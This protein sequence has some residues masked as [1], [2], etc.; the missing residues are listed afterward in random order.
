M[1]QYLISVLDDDTTDT[2][3]AEEMAADRCLQ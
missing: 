3:T 1:A 2:G